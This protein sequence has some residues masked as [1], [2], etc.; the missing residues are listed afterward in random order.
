[1][2][3]N[4]EGS[5]RAKRA[6]FQTFLALFVLFA[7]FASTL[8]FTASSDYEELCQVSAVSRSRHSGDDQQANLNLR[9]VIQ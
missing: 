4:A 6:K 8:A 1:M 7:L 5:K 3:W 2:R 9:G